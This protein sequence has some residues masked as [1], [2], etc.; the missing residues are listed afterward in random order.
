MLVKKMQQYIFEIAISATS[1][2]NEDHVKPQPVFSSGMLYL[3]CS[4]VARGRRKTGKTSKRKAVGYPNSLNCPSIDHV[5][6][7]NKQETREGQDP[8][9]VN[10]R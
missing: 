10:L 9:N 8:A 5:L 7:C 1:N 2:E 3:I 4:N 6:K